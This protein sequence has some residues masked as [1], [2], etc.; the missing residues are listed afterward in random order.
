ML[1]DIMGACLTIRRG[2]ASIRR[3]VVSV[4]VYVIR[5]AFLRRMFKM[6]C[7]NECTSSFTWR[8]CL[9]Y[10]EESDCEQKNQIVN[11]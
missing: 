9:W 10:I 7:T 4:Q 8:M 5:N 2:V 6:T 3:G 1:P 11:R